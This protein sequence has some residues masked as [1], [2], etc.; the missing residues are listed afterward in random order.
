M[1]CPAWLSCTLVAAIAAVIACL[2]PAYVGAQGAG[3]TTSP[4]KTQSTAAAANSPSYA[5]ESIVHDTTP[6][7]C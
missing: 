6:Y 5:E 3:T 2:R 7:G 1:R 4:T